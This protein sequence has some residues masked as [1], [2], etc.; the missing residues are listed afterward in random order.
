[1]TM[2]TDGI[3]GIVLVRVVLGFVK[4]VLLFERETPK[5]SSTTL[6][7]HLT[8]MPYTSHNDIDS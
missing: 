3:T 5:L 1:M 6:W 7:G 8:L 4:C 2:M